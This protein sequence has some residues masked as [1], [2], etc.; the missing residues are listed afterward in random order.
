[1]PKRKKSG[2]KRKSNSKGTN[3]LVKIQK[4]AKEYR[5]KHPNASPQTSV[6]EGSKKYNSLK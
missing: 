5:K 1:M 3:A 2:T 4:Y 6:K